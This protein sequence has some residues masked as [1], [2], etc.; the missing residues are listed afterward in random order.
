MRVRVASC[1]VLYLSLRCGVA[2]A[3][4]SVHADSRLRTARQR[5]RR[6]RRTD[7]LDRWWLGGYYRHHWIPGYITDPF[8]ASAPAISNDG[9]GLV[10]TYRTLGA[11]NVELGVGY[12]PY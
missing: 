4:T 3:Q 11:L 5:L 1:L 8:F 12:M 9:F 2:R 6:R 10:A 7:A